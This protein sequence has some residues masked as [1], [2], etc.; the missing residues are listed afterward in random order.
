MKTKSKKESNKNLK[1]LISAVGYFN[2][3]H[4][5]RTDSKQ[6]SG[7]MIRQNKMN[8][9]KKTRNN[10]TKARKRPILPDF[11]KSKLIQYHTITNE[12]YKEFSP[13]QELVDAF[14][15]QID[16]HY[17]NNIKEWFEGLGRNSLIFLGAGILFV[18]LIIFFSVYMRKK[19]KK[20]ESKL[21]KKKKRIE[22]K[23]KKK[24]GISTK[25][26]LLYSELKDK[27]ETTVS[28]FSEKLGISKDKGLD[29]KSV[30]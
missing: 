27:K 24:K 23:I 25:L 28:D 11:I 3:S 21:K 26:D 29:R 18:V 30:V 10:I 13:S 16:S 1:N 2:D 15:Y 9:G 14:F 6:N 22:N 4:N 19:K 12:C 7:R 20:K 8:H 5:N 17:F